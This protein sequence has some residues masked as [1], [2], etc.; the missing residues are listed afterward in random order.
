MMHGGGKSD[1]AIVA[2]KPPNKAGQPTAEPVER[3]AGT[4]GNAD[5]QS[6]LRAQNRAGVTQALARVREAAKDRK[7]ERFTT[8][9]HHVGIETLRTAFEALKRRAAAGV[10]GLTWQG[11]EAELEPRLAALHERVHRGSYR[12]LPSRRTYIPKADRQQRPLAI[13]AL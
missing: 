13:A 7:K 12:P 9:L 6:T 1:S 3:R 4:E 8:L 5:Q 11:Y 2:T 10:D